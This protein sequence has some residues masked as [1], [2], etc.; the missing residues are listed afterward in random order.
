M[1]E[2]VRTN[3][4]CRQEFAVEEMIEYGCNYSDCKHCGHNHNVWR[5]RRKLIEKYGL[6]KWDDGLYRLVLPRRRRGN[7]EKL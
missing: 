6:T 7:A 1:G 5:Y 2:P 3:K 4:Y